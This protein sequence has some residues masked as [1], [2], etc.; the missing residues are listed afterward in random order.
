MRRHPRLVGFFWRWH[1]RVGLTAA[2]LAIIL[3]VT[4]IALNHSPGMGL[5]K[6]YVTWSWI[7]P[8]YGDDIPELPAYRVAERWLYRNAAGQVYVDKAELAPCQGE[9]V[10]ALAHDGLFYIACAQELL[11]ATPGGELVESITA[12]T[13]LPVPLNGIGAAAGRVL[14]Q[15]GGKWLEADLERLAF[16]SSIPQDVI[17]RQHAPGPLPQSLR[18]SLLTRDHW[19]SWE[20]LLLDMHSGRLAGRAGVLLVDAAGLMLCILGLSGVAMWWLHRRGGRGR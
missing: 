11:L 15:A 18:E 20:R 7:Y 14:V 19:L 6:S 17:I 9:L 4:G 3:A 1:R 2:I 13:G 5:D 16:S 12:S 10:G 8:L